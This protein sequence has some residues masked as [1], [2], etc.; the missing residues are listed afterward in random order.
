[1]PAAEEWRVIAFTEHDVSSFCLF[2][3][4]EDE[5][6]KIAKEAPGAAIKS[7][8]REGRLSADR[9]H[10]ASGAGAGQGRC[11]EAHDG[12]G[13]CLGGSRPR[14]DAAGEPE[15]PERHRPRFLARGQAH[16]QRDCC[17]IRRSGSVS[18]VITC[19]ICGWNGLVTTAG[20]RDD[21]RTLK[22]PCKVVET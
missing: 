17:R 19:K 2:Q 16:L 4:P 9:Y 18:Y 10:R 8:D 6:R 1:M 7:P 14:A 20:R 5:A 21:P 22:V 12:A 15:I 3:G 11:R 13:G